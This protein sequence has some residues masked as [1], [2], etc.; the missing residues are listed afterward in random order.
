MTTILEDIQLLIE[1]SQMWNLP[2]D[3][4]EFMSLMGNQETK[5]YDA[6][7]KKHLTLYALDD[8]ERQN[9]ENNTLS[10]NILIGNNQINDFDSGR[11][12]SFN[13]KAQI[14][15]TPIGAYV[16]DEEQTEIVA[17]TFGEFIINYEVIS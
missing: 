11:R 2:K 3:Y 1:T 14:A 13:S 8:L 6:K 5:L 15:E 10:P 9:L 12:Y 17:E 4:L 7:R 16:E